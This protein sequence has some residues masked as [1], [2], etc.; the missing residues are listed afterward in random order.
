MIV[1]VLEVE[2]LSMKSL[3]MIHVSGKFSK[4]KTR[5]K[6]LHCGKA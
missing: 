4:K 3:Q 6:A 1:P 5:E 2:R